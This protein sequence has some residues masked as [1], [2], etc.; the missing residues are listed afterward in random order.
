[1][2]LLLLAFIVTGAFYVFGARL[3]LLLLGVPALCL[4]IVWLLQLKAG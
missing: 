3:L 2:A 1:M 4:A